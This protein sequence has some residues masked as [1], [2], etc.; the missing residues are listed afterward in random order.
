MKCPICASS[1][2]LKTAERGP[3]KGNNF[4]GCN[5]YPRCKGL[6]NV[7][8]NKKRKKRESA[9]MRSPSK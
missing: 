7:K 6:V 1:M 3:F 9:I 8:D 2:T 5:K 4:Y